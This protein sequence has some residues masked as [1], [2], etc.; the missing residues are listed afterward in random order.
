[1]K[2][3]TPVSKMTAEEFLDSKLKGSYIIHSDDGVQL[4]HGLEHSRMCLF[5]EQYT[6]RQTKSLK[7]EIERLKINQMSDEV[8]KD[9]SSSFKKDAQIVDLKKEIARCKFNEQ[10]AIKMVKRRDNIINQLDYQISQLKKEK[11]EAVKIAYDKG[12]SEGGKSNVKF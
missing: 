3:Q 9:L 8:S 4:I 11:K 12:F 5:I 7:E 10:T 2:D 6:E 1:M